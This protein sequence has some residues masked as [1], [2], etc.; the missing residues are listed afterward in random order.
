ML[1]TVTLYIIGIEFAI[2][3]REWNKNYPDSIFFLSIY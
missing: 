3:Y 1:V 2:K